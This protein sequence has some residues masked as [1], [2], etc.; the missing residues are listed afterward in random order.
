MEKNIILIIKKNFFFSKLS[1]LLEKDG[2][3]LKEL[4]DENRVSEKNLKKSF[5]FFFLESNGSI[6]E[7]KKLKIKNYNLVI[8]KNQKISASKNFPEATYINL[9]LIYNELIM[10]VNRL[11]KV[12]KTNNSQYKLGEYF[13]NAKTSQL[14]KEKSSLTINL[15]ELESKFL[16]YML[17]K[18]NGATKP[19]ILSEVWKHN[20]EL[21]THTLESLIYRLRK[22]IEKNPNEPSILI[23]DSKRYFLKL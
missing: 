1:R 14:F 18:N 11:N 20:K 3:L 9:P 13:Y 10:E 21:D 4:T 5:L 7:L 22:K 12:I 16:N 2:Y 8:F 19:Q 23:N 17:K 6:K 15:T